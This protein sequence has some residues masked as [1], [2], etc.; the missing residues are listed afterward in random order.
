MRGSEETTEIRYLFLSD[1][2]N[3]FRGH[4]RDQWQEL[5]RLSQKMATFGEEHE[6]YKAFK[7]KE[8]GDVVTFRSNQFKIVDLGF[9]D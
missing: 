7:G 6:V 4:T 3:T 1:R 5:G 2:I 8:I 9:D